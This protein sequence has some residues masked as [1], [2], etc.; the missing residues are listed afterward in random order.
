MKDFVDGACDGFVVFSLGSFV[1]M[2][3][4]PNETF[5][6]FASVFSRIGQRVVWK[7]ETGAPAGVP[8]NV[9]M[10]DWIPQ[11]DLLGD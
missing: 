3:S 6:T 9:Y 8:D 2:S 5:G 7:W 4:M 1:P 11:Q 10:T